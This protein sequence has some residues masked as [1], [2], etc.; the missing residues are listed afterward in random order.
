MKKT[1]ITNVTLLNEKLFEI[2]IQDHK[3]YRKSIKQNGS[4]KIYWFG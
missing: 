2:K 3:K 1:E 4:Q